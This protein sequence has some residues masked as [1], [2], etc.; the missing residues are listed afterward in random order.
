MI[1]QTAPSP[2]FLV[3]GYSPRYGSRDEIIGSRSAVE[4]TAETWAW[5]LRQLERFAAYLYDMGVTEVSIEIV[6][7][8]TG[9]PC[10]ENPDA[11]RAISPAYDPMFHSDDLPF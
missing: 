10:M 11:P 3:V 2:R 5:A 8:R 9:R 6:D 4:A 1:F 7:T